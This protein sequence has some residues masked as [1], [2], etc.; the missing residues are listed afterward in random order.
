MEELEKRLRGRGTDQEKVI[1]KRLEN[2]KLEMD[3]APQYSYRI[4]NDDLER[5]YHELKALIL[6]CLGLG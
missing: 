2:A 4:I 1:L 5:A 3:C 6:S